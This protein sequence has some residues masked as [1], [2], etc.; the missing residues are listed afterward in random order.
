MDK[1]RQYSLSVADFYIIFVADLSVI[2]KER[3]K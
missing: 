1:N 2:P 3:R